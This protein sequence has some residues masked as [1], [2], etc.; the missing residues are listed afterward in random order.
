MPKKQT[1]IEE[2]FGAYEEPPEAREHKNPKFGMGGKTEY[3]KVG[4][5]EPSGPSTDTGYP[6]RVSNTDQ[7]TYAT[8]YVSTTKYSR[9]S[10]LPMATLEHY[11]RGANVYLLS[12]AILCCIPTISPL[13]PLA[14][15]MPVVFVLS[16]SLIREGMEDYN[17]YQ[18]DEDLNNKVRGSPSGF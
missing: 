2:Q 11:K 18:H 12:I 4:G 16:I 9:F 5:D 13:M 14:A 15:V 1:P 7:G 8:N 17:R 10:F 3:E 6:R